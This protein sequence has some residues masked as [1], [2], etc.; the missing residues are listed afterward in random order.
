[1]RPG[2]GEAR[3]VA[4]RVV[5]AKASEAYADLAGTVADLR[6]KGR[7]PQVPPGKRPKVSEA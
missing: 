7:F 4:T 1:M 2:A 5:S 3:T 6:S